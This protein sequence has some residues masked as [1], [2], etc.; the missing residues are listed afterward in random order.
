LRRPRKS[1]AGRRAGGAAVDGRQCRSACGICL[2]KEDNGATLPGCGADTGSDRPESREEFRESAEVL[3][4]SVWNCHGVVVCFAGEK[5]KMTGRVHNTEE[6][7]RQ[8]VG[9]SCQQVEC[10][11]SVNWASAREDV[12]W[13]GMVVGQPMK[14]FILLYFIIY[15]P[16]SISKFTLNFE[17]EFKL[18][19]N[20]ILN[21]FIKF[22]SINSENIISLYII[23]SPFSFPPISFNSSPHYHY[24]IFIHFITI[25][26]KCTTNKTPI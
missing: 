18:V 11:C 21:Y 2:G 23:Y 22:K 12:N 5:K 1:R 19:S 10:G 26:L 4:I 20:F 6:E 17:F 9:P 15:S 14:S 13:A 16:F 24:Y 25:V 3:A 8:Q 7:P